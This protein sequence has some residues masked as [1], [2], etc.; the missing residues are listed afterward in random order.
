MGVFDWLRRGRGSATR[1]VDAASPT[2]MVAGRVRVRGVPYNL[3]RDPE[4]M[5]R[6]D[7]QH[8]MFRYALRGNYAAPV[9]APT[10]I[11]DVGTGTGRWAREMA[12][13][14]PQTNV[15]GLDVNPLPPSM[16]QRQPAPPA[17]Y[18][19]SIIASQRVRSLKGYPSPMPV[20][21]SCICA[22]S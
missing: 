8:Y 10:S 19:R 14:F 15:V 11:L 20:S 18:A 13:L 17:S 7:F 9:N 5:N 3:P 6:L 4:E 2:S 1:V 22:C 12:H 21:T 16:R